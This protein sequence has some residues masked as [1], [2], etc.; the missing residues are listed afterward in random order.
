MKAKN[1]DT[2]PRYR[3]DT[4][5][6]SWGEWSLYNIWDDYESEAIPINDGFPASGYTRDRAY[7][8]RICGEM[9]ARGDSD[10]LIYPNPDFYGGD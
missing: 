10:D 7:A 3:V 6:D 1:G 4:H 2:V 9:N 8:D 5:K